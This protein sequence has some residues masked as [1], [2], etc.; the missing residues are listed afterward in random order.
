VPFCPVIAGL[1]LVVIN[2]VK[3]I[4]HVLLDCGD[5]CKSGTY[6]I[7]AIMMSCVLRFEYLN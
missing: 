2:L 7:K 6:I 1:L 4:L 3:S 5:T